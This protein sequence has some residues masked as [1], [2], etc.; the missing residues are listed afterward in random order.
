M[1]GE[2][3]VINQQ[4]SKAK[5]RYLFLF[6][7]TLLLCKP[8]GDSFTFI[9]AYHI[10]NGPYQEVQMPMR[11]GEKYSFGFTLP[12]SH[13]RTA[14][15]MIFF[16]KSAEL[17]Q[18]WLQAIQT[19][20]SNLYPPGAKDKGYNFEMH[21]FPHP[22]YC[23]VCN[24]LL[25][26]IFFQGYRC[27]DTGLAAHKACLAMNNLPP[28]T[29]TTNPS[30][31]LQLNGIHPIAPQPP[32]LPPSQ[33]GTYRGRHFQSGPGLTSSASAA[34]LGMSSTLNHPCTPSPFHHSNS[35]DLSHFSEA[36]SFMNHCF[37]TD[38]P[39]YQQQCRRTASSLAGGHSAHPAQPSFSV[40]VRKA[41]PYDPQTHMVD[42]SLSLQPGDRVE[43]LN[44]SDDGAWCRGRCR[45]NEGWF[46][47]HILEPLSMRPYRA[48][49]DLGQMNRY[50]T[51]LP[52]PSPP[53]AAVTNPSAFSSRLSLLQHRHSLSNDGCDS[54][55][56]H[57]KQDSWVTFDS[58][59]AP[60]A[61]DSVESSETPRSDWYV[62][63]MDRAEAVTL[64]SNCP[65]GTFLVRVSKSVE[66]C[67]E[68]SL[69]LTYGYPRHIRIQRVPS[70]DGSSFMYGLCESEHFPSIASMVEHYSKVSL[71]RCFDEVDTKLLYPYKRCPASVLFFVR[72][73]FDF[74]SDS[75]P[76]L[77]SLKRDDRIAVL[78]RAAEDRGWWKGWLHGHI[79]FFPMSYV[80]RD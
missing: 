2:V 72:A 45:G 39:Q 50:S 66:R 30:G 46:P 17:R 58:E 20:I 77:L 12:I 44:W 73:N 40:T 64:L 70:A 49:T 16:T 42:F 62:G 79:G 10:T 27:R 36:L 7:K 28:R 60:S 1:D 57:L 56:L 31:T 6:D 38:A 19:S 74:D 32:P 11:K 37:A 25:Q 13:S 52:P 18:R 9:I 78:S 54:N 34:V 75:N 22:T 4:D 21:T 26:G 35:N 61:L 3:K 55:G 5:I 76:R 69:S 23:C 14:V 80:G 68:Y 47:A 29:G 63:E 65:D 67:G 43:V 48:T 15:N 33:S 51:Q 53:S 24:K 41:Y 71:N 59:V 8:K